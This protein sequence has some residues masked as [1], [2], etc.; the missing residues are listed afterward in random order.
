[1][2]LTVTNE[3]E[4][5]LQPLGAVT[6]SGNGAACDVTRFRDAVVM[7]DVTAVSGTSPTM[8]AKIQTSDDGG[9]TWYDL[10]SASFTAAT[11]ATTQAIQITNF[12]DTIR[13]AYTVGGTTPSFTFSVKAILKEVK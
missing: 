9:T 10:P 13:A 8:T 2:T 1:M 6:A 4:I 11:A 5:T 12:G 7:L 3:N